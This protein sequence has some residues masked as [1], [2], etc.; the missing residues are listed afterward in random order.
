M[1]GCVVLRPRDRDARKAGA[2]WWVWARGSSPSVCRHWAADGSVSFYFFV[3]NTSY[4]GGG[5]ST[6]RVSHSFI[7]QTALSNASGR[8]KRISF[9]YS[10]THLVH[11]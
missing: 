5:G 11:F 3:Y 2:I 8:Q 7:H 6:L 1:Q 4:K 9:I 10:L